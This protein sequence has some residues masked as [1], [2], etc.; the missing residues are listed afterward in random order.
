MRFA[1]SDLILRGKF[2]RENPSFPNSPFRYEQQWNTKRRPSFHQTNEVAGVSHGSASQ[3][4]PDEPLMERIDRTSARYSDTITGLLLFI[5][6][7]YSISAP[8][9]DG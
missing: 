8:N 5:P 4:F 9:M 7:V 2:P 1:T 3:L 6:A